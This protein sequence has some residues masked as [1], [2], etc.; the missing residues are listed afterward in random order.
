MKQVP[1]PFDLSKLP[2]GFVENPY[3]YYAALVSDTPVLEQ[4]D[5][6][7]L[8]SSYQLLDAIY[9][10]TS[11]YSSDKTVTFVSHYHAHIS[12]NLVF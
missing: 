6:S 11:T 7:F 9:K 1:M 8:V 2:Y 4:P 10:D 12:F 3:P 5:G